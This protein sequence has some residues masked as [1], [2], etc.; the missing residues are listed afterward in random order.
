MPPK[1]PWMTRMTSSMSPPVAAAHPI[2]ESVKP[3]IAPHEQ[4]AQ[5]QRARQ[6]AGQRNGDDFGDQVTGLDP[7]DAV[8][9]DRERV[10]DDV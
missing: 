5:R 10:L 7:G 4:P 6:H 1:K 8:V 9:G 3:V 2:L